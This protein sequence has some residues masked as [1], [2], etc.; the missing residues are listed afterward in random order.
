MLKK[1]EEKKCKF[2][3]SSLPLRD[4]TTGRHN[5]ARGG[6][7]SVWGGGRECVGGEVEKKEEERK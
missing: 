7:E 2:S 4:K 6:E 5:G 3:S 1:K